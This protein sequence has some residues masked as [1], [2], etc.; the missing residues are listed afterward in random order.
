MEKRDFLK[1]SALF[2]AGLFVLPGMTAEQLLARPEGSAASKGPYKLPKLNYGYDAL[3]PHFDA[4]TM[5]IHHKAHHQA[6]IDKLN[7]AVIEAKQE[8]TPL[9]KL[10]SSLKTNKK[11]AEAIRHFGGGHWNHTFWWESLTNI[12]T[13]PIGGLDAAIR[14]QWGALSVLKNEF[15]KAA[16]AQFGSGWAWLIVNESKKLQIV[17]TADQ[18]NPLMDLPGNVKGIPV[19]GLDVWEHAYYLKYQ[20]KRKD[21]TEAF[22][23]VIDWSLAEQRFQAALAAGGKSK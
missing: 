12:K 6:Y 15:N 5:E 19:L 11:N 10:F 1:A 23:N 14:T 18:D 2:T 20:N 8:T 16:L 9:E 7:E 22:W 13:A 17:S 4:K 3:E 21:Y